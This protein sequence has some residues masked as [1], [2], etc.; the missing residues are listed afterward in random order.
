MDYAD[1]DA[2]CPSCA[3]AP[4][5]EQM[6]NHVCPVCDLLLCDLQTSYSE[7]LMSAA[8]YLRERKKETNINYYLWVKNDNN[9]DLLMRIADRSDDFIPRLNT[10]SQAQIEELDNFY[11]QGFDEGFTVCCNIPL[12]DAHKCI[13][14]MTVVYDDVLSFDQAHPYDVYDREGGC[15]DCEYYYSRSCTPYFNSILE[16]ARTKRPNESKIKE[17]SDFAPFSTKSYESSYYE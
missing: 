8:T 13:C 6:L 4:T 3:H 10:D 14:P 15:A 16:F 1:V 5:I 17:C 11:Y 7:I 2:Q 9:E 12:E